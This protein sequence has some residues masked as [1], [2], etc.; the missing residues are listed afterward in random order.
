M[1]GQL[2]VLGVPDMKT[3]QSSLGKGVRSRGKQLTENF[4]NHSNKPSRPRGSLIS[5]KGAYER[6]VGLNEDG[7]I[8]REGGGG[9]SIREHLNNEGLQKKRGLKAHQKGRIIKGAY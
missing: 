4:H 8:F 9:G 1:P 3:L 6:G 5:G 7:G 2:T